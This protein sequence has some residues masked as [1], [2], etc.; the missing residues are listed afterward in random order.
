MSSCVGEFCPECRKILVAARELAF[1]RFTAVKLVGPD[2]EARQKSIRRYLPD[3]AT[4]TD[5]E[6]GV[7][8][9]NLT[10]HFESLTERNLIASADG[11]GNASWY[12]L[13]DEGISV[14][15][16]L[17]AATE[18]ES[19]S[20]HLASTFGAEL[21][22]KMLRLD[23]LIGDRHW[24]SV[25]AY[26]ESILRRMLQARLPRRF[27]VSTGFIA[28]H[29]RG[30]R[31]LSRQMDILIWD[32][33]THSPIFQDEDMVVIPFEAAR[34]AV[35]VKSTAD[36][37]SIATALRNLN[38][39]DQFIDDA[40]VRY[41]TALYRAAFFYQPRHGVSAPERLWDSLLESYSPT[42]SE[43]LSWWRRLSQ[44]GARPNR[45][46]SLVNSLCILSHGT[47]LVQEW[48]LN[49]TTSIVY[50]WFEERSGQ[51]AFMT[52]ST[53][54]IQHVVSGGEPFDLH[55][56]R[57]GTAEALSATSAQVDPEN[58][59]FLALA[60]PADTTRIGSLDETRSAA[61]WS[62]RYTPATATT[63]L[64]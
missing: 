52:F 45:M 59:R 54:L 19:I 21:R 16:E 4:G 20:R 3:D 6:Y 61:L 29:R 10:P 15:E 53:D 23:R 22:T 25:G 32:S 39:I 64:G 17:T 43:R 57:P 38:S 24:L 41:E 58:T 9:S 34:A 27:S 13:T 46:L 56:E 62:N 42:L 2:T 55:F 37:E 36:S 33:H 40:Y 8:A 60:P 63:E 51:D 26:K 48:D 35:E 18:Y 7:L 11:P 50:P 47:T 28:G 30:Q 31:L 1:D 12:N 14:A 5:A 44:G 49:G